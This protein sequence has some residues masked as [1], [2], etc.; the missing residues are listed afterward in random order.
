MAAKIFG[1]FLCDIS[2]ATLAPVSQVDVV[3]TNMGLSP[4][5]FT[6]T[7]LPGAADVVERAVRRIEYRNLHGYDYSFTLFDA[8]LYPHKFGPVK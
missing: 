1:N 5:T 2:S 4:G 3:M 7:L 8:L 6:V